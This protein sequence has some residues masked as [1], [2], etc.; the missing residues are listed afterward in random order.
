MF[1]ITRSQL[2]RRGFPELVECWHT[3]SDLRGLAAVSLLQLKGAASG[4]GATANVWV[5]DG[6]YVRQP[7]RWLMLTA[8][9][10]NPAR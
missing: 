10:A 4:W 6:G 9:F 8:V 5:A 3:L 2:C 1:Y 7:L